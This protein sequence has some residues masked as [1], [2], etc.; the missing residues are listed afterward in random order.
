MMSNVCNTP[1]G[2]QSYAEEPPQAQHILVESRAVDTNKVNPLKWEMETIED[3]IWLNDTYLVNQQDYIFV[4]GHVDNEFGGCGIYGRVGTKDISNFMA[5]KA[6][7]RINKLAVDMQAVIKA[8]EIWEETGG[9]KQEFYIFTDCKLV[10]SY[11]NVHS[12]LDDFARN[13]YKLPG[14]QDI[15]YSLFGHALTYFKASHRDIYVYYINP[16]LCFLPKAQE[17]AMMGSLYA[18]EKISID[19][20]GEIFTHDLHVDL[21]NL[22]NKY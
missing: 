15:D 2:N 9:K 16:N 22:L 19:D 21:G 10:A 1:Y 11:F 8:F 12:K 4:S 7:S 17:L 6:E 3:M 13:G 14:V 20:N 5:L 18:E